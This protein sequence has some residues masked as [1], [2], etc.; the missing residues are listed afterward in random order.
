[1]ETSNFTDVTLWTAL[2]L[3]TAFGFRHALET[4]HVLTIS[5]IVPRERSFWRSTAVGA[6]WGLGHNIS[7]FVIG[8]LVIFLKWRVPE[9]LATGV[10]FLIACTLVLLGANAVLR[11]RRGDGHVCR[12]AHGTDEHAVEHEHFHQHGQHACAGDEIH[13]PILD[14]STQGVTRRMLWQSFALGSAHAL[15]ASSVLMMVVLSAIPTPLTGFAYLASFG[16]GSVLAMGAVSLA[17]TS[18]FTFA[19]KRMRGAEYSLQGAVGIASM[20]FG[21]YLIYGIGVHVFKIV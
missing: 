11:W 13:A 7:L 15:C 6:V 2:F 14:R 17:F 5:A 3:G 20:A 19:G 12:H 9:N 4:D 21:L 18:A 10:E 1:M 8:L 16:I